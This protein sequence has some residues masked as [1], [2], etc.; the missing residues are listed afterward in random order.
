MILDEATLVLD[1]CADEGMPARDIASAT[2]VFTAGRQSH[3]VGPSPGG[4]AVGPRPT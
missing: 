1:G 2:G 4:Q 3:G